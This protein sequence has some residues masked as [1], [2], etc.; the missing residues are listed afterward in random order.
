MS[1]YYS[2]S[3]K[4]RLE[5][6]GI[7]AI[8]VIAVIL[9]HADSRF[10]AGGFLGVD[11]FFVISGYLISNIIIGKLESE[12]FSIR[13]FYMRRA[14]RILPALFFMTFVSVFLAWLFMSPE[15]ILLFAKSVL[16]VNLLVSNLFF[17]RQHDYFDPSA[18]FIPLIHTWSLGVEE[19]FYIFFPLILIFLYR[20]SRNLVF[21]VILSLTFFSLVLA[22]WAYEFMPAATF[23]LAPTRAWEFLIGGLL[24]MYERNRILRP[25]TLIAILGIFLII[26]SFLWF[27]QRTPNPGLFTLLPVV[28]TLLF[29]RYSG[30]N[31]LIVRVFATRTIRLIGLSSYSIYLWHQPLFSFSRIAFGEL[32]NLE[33]FLT[34]FLALFL[35]FLSWKFVETPFRRPTMTSGKFHLRLLLLYFFFTTTFSVLIITNS[36]FPST[37]ALSDS[38]VIESKLDREIWVLGDSHAGSLISGLAASVNYPVRDFSSPGCIPLINVDRYDFRGTPGLCKNKFDNLFDTIIDKDPN[39]VIIITSMVPV[40]FEGTAFKDQGK[41]RLV[42]QK[43]FWYGARELSNP[44]EIFREGLESTFSSLSSTSKATI[45]YA[46]D[47]PE[48]GIPYGCNKNSKEVNFSFATLNDL[49]S[50]P[51]VDN[52]KISRVD[53]DNRTRLYRNIVDMV[54]R[55]YPKILI[56]D[57]TSSFCNTQDCTGF[58]PEF[59]HLYRDYDHL[60]EVGSKFWAENFLPWINA[61]MTT[62]E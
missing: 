28:G 40:Y 55:N 42:G 43:V 2:R 44:W 22:D 20:F 31:S 8:A 61:R 27:D 35:G 14:R 12:T 24:S 37:K 39:A 46:L 49:V 52:C 48:L 13:E 29:L 32:S 9:F 11:V 3:M 6:D 18:E 4:Y 59:G 56:Y 19:Q 36:G 30:E 60:S 51:L 47:V 41:G 34:I 15:E 45:V 1:P 10:L 16:S 26:F 38:P 23:Y 57:P 53:F 62:S 33:T 25:Q 17:W 54:S 7:R 58:H 21:P 50:S 5:I